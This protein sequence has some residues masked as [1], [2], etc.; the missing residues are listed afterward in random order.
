MQSH[1]QL[2]HVSR[3]KVGQTANYGF[4]SLALHHNRTSPSG[5]GY[6]KQD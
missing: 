2:S 1:T 6:G 5:H 4:A 3:N